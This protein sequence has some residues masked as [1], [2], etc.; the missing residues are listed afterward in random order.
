MLIIFGI[1]RKAY[2]LATVFAVCSLCHTPAAQ[3]VAR[4]R[5]F[6]SLFFI[7]LIPLTSRYRM[8][9]TMCGQSVSITAA[10]ASQ[11][12][13]A[14]QAQARGHTQ[15]APLPAPPAPGSTQAADGGLPPT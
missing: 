1:R 7:P 10:D 9:C 12:V 15:A 5:T 4:V 8:T 14:A 2:R 3:A 13:A 11:L 6:F